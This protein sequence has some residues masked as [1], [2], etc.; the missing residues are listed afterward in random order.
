MFRSKC[1]YFFY[2]CYCLLAIYNK[3]FN[4]VSLTNSILEPCIYCI[5]IR[6]SDI[7]GSWYVYI[8]KEWTF[9]DRIT[10]QSVVHR[11]AGR[12]RTG[13]NQAERYGEK[14]NHVKIYMEHE[15]LCKFCR[16]FPS[17]DFILFFDSLFIYLFVYLFIHLLI[18]LFTHLF[19]YKLL[20]IYLLI[21]L[22][23]VVIY[24]F[25]G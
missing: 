25:I 13:R 22:L 20:S 5:F 8:M 1:N 11:K 4:S 12:W 14:G 18:D 17:L 21:H 9:N 19:V 7:F 10:L 23:Q 24:L 3:I 6:K 15:T 2:L 16:I